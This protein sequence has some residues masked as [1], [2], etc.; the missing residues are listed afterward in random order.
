MPSSAFGP[1]LLLSHGLEFEETYP[2]LHL[3]TLGHWASAVPSNELGPLLLLSQGD[4]LLETYPGLHLATDG[5]SALREMALTFA[6]NKNAA[7]I[8]NV[9]L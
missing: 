3:A 4:E 2:G 9:Y 6:I 7:F 8:F 1:L 5:Q